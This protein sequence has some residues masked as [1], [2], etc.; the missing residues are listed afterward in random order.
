MKQKLLI[1]LIV[2][3]IYMDVAI[4][5][6][7]VEVFVG[8]KKTS[9]D[10]MFFRYF[11]NKEATN[12]KF[13]FFNRNRVS[14]DY[15]QTTTTNLPTFAFTEA[16]SYNLSKLKG[17]AP[18]LVAQ[19]SNRGVFP[20]SGIQYYYGKN[21]FTFFSWVVCELLADPNID[22]FLL[23]R[24]QTKLTTKLNLF[25]QLE[26]INAFPTV[27]TN[28]YNLIQRVRLGLKMREWQFGSGVDF[29]EFGNKTIVSTNNIGLF[30]RHEF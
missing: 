18:V 9:F 6:L 25:T 8:N 10:L 1:T 30:L 2:T 17:F 24:Y 5:Q 23:A 26:L 4:S 13:L 7:P 3:F 12:S 27:S 20:K 21:D 11:K 19:V 15:K 14:I 28:N 22:F 16:V 29:N